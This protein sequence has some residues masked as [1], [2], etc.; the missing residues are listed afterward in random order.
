[1]A[2]GSPIEHVIVLMMENH[3]FDNAL[4]YLG[5][6]DG[7][8]SEMFN[9][10]DPAD[11]TSQKIFV[12]SNATDT[13]DPDPLHDLTDTSIELF[14][15][16]VNDTSVATM[17][18]FVYDYTQAADGDVNVGSSIMQCYNPIALPTLSGL[19]NEFCLCDRW[20]ASMPGPTLPNRFFV[21]AAT[22]DGQAGNSFT[23]DYDMN[24]IYNN[25]AD[26]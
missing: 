13:T 12:G 22:S 19:A 26:N 1:M 5:K 15:P 20:F 3:T 24:T 4:G 2:N 14:A 8:T 17:S 9:L 21:H 16:N 11:P 25:L 10:V 6:G 7:V 18:G 23:H